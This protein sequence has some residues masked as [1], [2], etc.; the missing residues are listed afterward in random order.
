MQNEELY[1]KFK[2]LPKEDLNYK[3]R[4]AC[5]HGD[6]EVIKYLLTSSDLKQQA[7]IHFQRDV[8][9]KY[10]CQNSLD[11][12]RFFVF[13]MNIEKTLTIKQY[14]KKFP[15]EQVENMF[16]LRELNQKLEKELDS[17]NIRNKQIKV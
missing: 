1:N 6:L 5:L 16:K 7:D 3:F 17:A 9:F 12:V 4:I 8:G 13:D 11:I 2:D 14:L 10:A 15:N